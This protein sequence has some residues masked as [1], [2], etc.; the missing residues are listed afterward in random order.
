MLKIVKASKA[1]CFMTGKTEDCFEVK[2]DDKSFQGVLS[3]PELLKVV[4]RKCHETA[5][6]SGGSGRLADKQ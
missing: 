2:F 4:K 5:D 1:P 3:W 6:H